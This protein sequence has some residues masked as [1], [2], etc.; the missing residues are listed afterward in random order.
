VIVTTV[1]TKG[2]V[3]FAIGIVIKFSFADCANTQFITHTV[4][5]YFIAEFDCTVLQTKDYR[6]SYAANKAGCICVAIVCHFKIVPIQVVVARVVAK[7]T[8]VAISVLA[9][10]FNHFFSAIFAV[11][12]FIFCADFAECAYVTLFIFGAITV[13]D[14]SSRVTFTVTV[15]A[16]FLVAVTL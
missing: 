16:T 11:A 6:A 9:V 2:A 7:V 4:K 10:V 5:Q 15:F 8:F 3:I 12:V 13:G 14:Y 1:V